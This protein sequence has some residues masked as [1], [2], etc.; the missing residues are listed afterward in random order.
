MLGNQRMYLK[1]VVIYQ[2]FWHFLIVLAVGDMVS[3]WISFGHQV[4]IWISFGCTNQG[5]AAADGSGRTKA[6][7]KWPNLLRFS[8][9]ALLLLRQ[10]PTAKSSS[11]SSNLSSEGIFVTLYSRGWR[12][13]QNQSRAG[14]QNQTTTPQNEHC[15]TAWLAAYEVCYNIRAWG[16]N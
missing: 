9:P 12:V 8:N 14:K 4:G 11:S 13:L 6:E 10:L 16:N 15:W 1:V 2:C 7:E 3:I 5:A